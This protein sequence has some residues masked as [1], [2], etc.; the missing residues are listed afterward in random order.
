[1]IVIGNSKIRNVEIESWK[2]LEELGN[3]IGFETDLYFNY[4][5]QNPYIRIPRGS[6]GGIINSDHVLILKKR[7]Q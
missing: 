7:G 1:M 4:I 3:L 5:I 6:K 2:V